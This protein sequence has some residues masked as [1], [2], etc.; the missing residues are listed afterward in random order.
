MEHA[1]AI[2]TG[3]RGSVTGKVKALEKAGGLAAAKPSQVGG[4]L[5]QAL[6]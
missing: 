5:K 4:L 3:G 6:G 1:G 2:V